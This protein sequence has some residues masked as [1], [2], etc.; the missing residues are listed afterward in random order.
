MVTLLAYDFTASDYRR[1]PE[2][3]PAELIRGMLVREPSP[4]AYHQGLALK[5]G[6]RLAEVAGVHRVLLAPIDV[7]LDE[8]SVLQP[9]VLL[10]GAADAWGPE[11]RQTAI[12]ALVVEVLSPSIAI[13]DREVKTDLYLRAGVEEV[14]LVDP[15]ARTV[16]AR[17]ASGARVV[18]A[19]G[20]I[21]TPVLPG[22]AIDLKE[23]FS[24]SRS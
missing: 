19:P 24:W 12:P 23:L 20:S 4:T 22:L 6:M 11:V 18:V 21:A 17:T 7:H 5:I 16:E 9:D 14:W 10:L 2:G 1:L 8:S 13:R 3:F 15:D